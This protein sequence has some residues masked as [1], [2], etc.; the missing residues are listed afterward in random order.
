MAN[1]EMNDSWNPIVKRDEGSKNKETK[2][3][4]AKEFNRLALLLER[5]L[6]T[7]TEYIA[8]ARK[9]DGPAPVIKV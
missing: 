2:P 7:N 5:K 4:K 8:T 3:A 9:V 6:K 1:T